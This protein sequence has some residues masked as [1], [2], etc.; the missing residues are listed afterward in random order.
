M[1][2]FARE[3]GE[4]EKERERERERERKNGTNSIYLN[5]AKGL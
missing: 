3:R 5:A 1:F 2:E 4:R